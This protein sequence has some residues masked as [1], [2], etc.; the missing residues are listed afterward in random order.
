MPARPRSSYL[1]STRSEDLGTMMARFLSQHN[2]NPVLLYRLRSSVLAGS[3]HSHYDIEGVVEGTTGD[4]SL[5]LEG[6]VQIVVRAEST[7]G[8]I[9][10]G[11]TPSA[12]GVVV[13]ALRAL[14]GPELYAPS[15]YEHGSG[16]A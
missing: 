10:S 5:S 8:G 7:W 3:R 4:V 12:L 16:T 2:S 9:R 15:C 13:A 14:L 6:R 11:A 1:T